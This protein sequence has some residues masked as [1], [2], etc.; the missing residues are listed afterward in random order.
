[1]FSQVKS[2]TELAV[3]EIFGDGLVV[4]RSGYIDPVRPLEKPIC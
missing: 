2:E 1:M 4:F 3:R